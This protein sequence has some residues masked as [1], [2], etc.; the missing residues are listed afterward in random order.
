MK[1]TGIFTENYLSGTEKTGKILSK[2]KR[3]NGKTGTK[4][5]HSAKR[6]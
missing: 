4:N 6:N 1:K 2:E 3:M 5:R